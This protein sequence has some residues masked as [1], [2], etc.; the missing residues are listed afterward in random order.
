MITVIGGAIKVVQEITPEEEEP[1]KCKLLDKPKD[2]KAV[3]KLAKTPPTQQFS[4]PTDFNFGDDANPVSISDVA[5]GASPVLQSIVNRLTTGARHPKG[6]QPYFLIGPAGS[7]KSH[8]MRHLKKYGVAYA[9]LSSLNKSLRKASHP[10]A[11][12]E[13]D[14]KIGEQDISWLAKL[15][16]DA[17]SL[18]LE[19]LVAEVNGSEPDFSKGILLDS[20]DE[21]HPDSSRHILMKIHDY[22]TSHPEKVVIVAGRGE[23]FRDYFVANNLREVP[24]CAIPKM[25]VGNEPYM[26]WFINENVYY[27]LRDSNPSIGTLES[28]VAE[29][30]E[31]L[32]SFLNAHP[33]AR[34][35]LYPGALGN[36]AV[37]NVRY[38]NEEPERLEALMFQTLIDRNK[39]THNR[40]VKDDKAWG[41]YRDAL[42]QVARKYVPNGNGVFLVGPQDTV[43]VKDGEFWWEVNV[44]SVLV[45]SGLVDLNPVNVRYYEFMFWPKNVHRIL[46]NGQLE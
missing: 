29:L 25:Y 23:A 16:K 6:P 28:A 34:H 24:E 12:K 1:V 4:L 22:A 18:N 40:P 11:S 10:L 8:L 39:G 13:T 15:T 14:L 45:R 21:I 44:A 7:G 36:F 27:R 17:L 19:G 33:F 5:I 31:N 20:L 2:A 46:A 35:Y 26:T 42:I 38:S 43:C 9:N 32:A 37:D 30:R 41:L 3:E